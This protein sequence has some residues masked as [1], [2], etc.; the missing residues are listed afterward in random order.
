MFIN[1]ILQNLEGSE[2]DRKLGL[3]MPEKIEELRQIVT[4]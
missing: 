1:K 4:D 2:E 3:Y